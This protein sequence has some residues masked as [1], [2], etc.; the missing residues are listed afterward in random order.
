[1]RK[2]NLSW[3]RPSALLPLSRGLSLTRSLGLAGDLSSA[4]ALIANVLALNDVMRISDDLGARRAHFTKASAR[5]ATLEDAH[6]EAREER[7][8]GEVEE[9]EEVEKTD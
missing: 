8:D 6:Q 1:M 4:F 3:L 2:L 5:L 9:E 7:K